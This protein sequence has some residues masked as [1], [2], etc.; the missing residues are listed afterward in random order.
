MFDLAVSNDIG[1]AERAAQALQK[2][3]EVF[4]LV[5]KFLEEASLLW[6]EC[7]AW[8][9]RLQEYRYR[10]LWIRFL[11]EDTTTMLFSNPTSQG[12]PKVCSVGLS[13]GYKRSSL[14]G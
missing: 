2:H 12:E 5:E 7:S 3:Q 10:P 11:K 4:P 1:F 14:A 13:H 8:A 9:T 6:H